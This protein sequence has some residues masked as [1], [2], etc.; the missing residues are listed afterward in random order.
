MGN[1]R[2]STILELYESV[3]G[4][5]AK[6]DMKRYAEST[7]TLYKDNVFVADE[8]NETKIKD[9]FVDT[10]TYKKIVRNEKPYLV[11]KKDNFCLSEDIHL[12][13]ISPER[14]TVYKTIVNIETSSDEPGLKEEYMILTLQ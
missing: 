4:P 1:S 3:S 7:Q 6:V 10:E 8:I 14:R 11:L 13:E 5:V 2:R 12:I 9:I